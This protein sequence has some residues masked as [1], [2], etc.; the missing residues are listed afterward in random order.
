MFSAELRQLYHAPIPEDRGRIT[1]SVR[2]PVLVDGI[3][4]KCFQIATIAAV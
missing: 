2:I 1:E 3:K 4:Q